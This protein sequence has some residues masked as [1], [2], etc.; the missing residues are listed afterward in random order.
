[1]E[2]LEDALIVVTRM[3]SNKHKRHVI[4]GVFISIS[5]LFGTLALTVVS[6]K[7]EENDY[8]Y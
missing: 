8:E 5:V 1:M 4:G 6:M 2:R 7:H 3:L